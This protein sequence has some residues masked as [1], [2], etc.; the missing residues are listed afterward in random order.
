LGLHSE[1]RLG[2]EFDLRLGASLSDAE[3]PQMLLGRS[4]TMA[5]LSTIMLT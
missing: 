4:E 1:G 2:V 3:L 5:P